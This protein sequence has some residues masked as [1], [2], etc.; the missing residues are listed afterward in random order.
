[1]AKTFDEFLDGEYA[2]PKTIDST[3]KQMA[4]TVARNLTTIGS[5][6]V[7]FAFVCIFLFDLELNTKLTVGLAA[8]AVVS[9][10]LFHFFRAFQGEDGRKSGKADPDYVASKE[11][12]AE[13]LK[14]LQKIGTDRMQDFCDEY[15][16]ENLKARRV[17]ILHPARVGYAAYEALYMDVDK[18][19]VM[20]DNCLTRKQRLAVVAANNLRPAVLTPDMIVLGDF[21]ADLNASIMVAPSVKDRRQVRGGVLTTVLM[22]LFSSAIAFGATAA[23]TL[24]KA[25]YCFLKL[26]LMLFQGIKERYQ[27]HILYS[28]DAVKYN[29]WL[30]AMI[31]RYKDF[32]TRAREVSAHDKD[33]IYG[34]DGQGNGADRKRGESVTSSDRDALRAVP[35]RPVQLRDLDGNAHEPAVVLPQKESHG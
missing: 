29:D 21:G 24:A 20:R 7:I 2:E 4:G 30:T 1:M 28:V 23:P 26:C 11:R 15:V 16:A 14:D 27:K 25:V 34:H 19:E 8:D 18:R 13:R 32:S 12:Y 5:V 17:K 22:A 10:I 3:I 35:G 31:G 33:Q 6:V 9:A